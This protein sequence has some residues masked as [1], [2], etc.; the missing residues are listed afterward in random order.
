MTGGMGLLKSYYAP[1]GL[2]PFMGGYDY[3]IGNY[4]FFLSFI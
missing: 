1:V 4:S 3:E 2:P